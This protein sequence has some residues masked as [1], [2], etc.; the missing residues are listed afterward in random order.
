MRSPSRSVGSSARPTRVQQ[1]WPTDD[2]PLSR[3]ERRELQRLLIARGHDVGE[4]DGAIGA[5]T[6]AAIQAEESRF[7]MRPTGRPGGKILHAL[8]GTFMTRRLISSGSPFEAAMA[9]RAPSPTVTSCS[10]PAPP[11]TTT[12]P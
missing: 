6:R 12:A 11:V 4:P 7:G 10:S 1:R 9:T 2:P 8:R 3:A 5:K